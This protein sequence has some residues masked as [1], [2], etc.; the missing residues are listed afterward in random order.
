MYRFCKNCHVPNLI[1][2]TDKD[3]KP[4]CLE[5]NTTLRSNILVESDKHHY[6]IIDV[7]DDLY[8]IMND[9]FSQS[10]DYLTKENMIKHRT[11]KSSIDDLKMSIK[12][13]RAY[14]RYKTEFFDINNNRT[15]SSE[16][17]LGR[18]VNVCV[19]LDYIWLSHVTWGFTWKVIYTQASNT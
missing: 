9:I 5:I 3:R 13:Q 1:N 15:V 7:N 11:F 12:L 6:I 8:N 10:E 19:A 2:I 16:L 17:Q 18:K 4:L 14:N